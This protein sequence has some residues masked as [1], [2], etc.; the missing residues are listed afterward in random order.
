MST[1]VTDFVSWFQQLPSPQQHELYVFIVQEVTNNQHQGVP[2]RR[3]GVTVHFGGQR[4]GQAPKERYERAAG[5]VCPQ[6]HRPF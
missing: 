6:C 3:G 1:V 2:Q 5:Q 4:G